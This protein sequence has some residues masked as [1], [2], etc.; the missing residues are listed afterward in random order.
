MIVRLGP[1]LV[2]ASINEAKEALRAALASGE[3]VVLDTAALTEADFAGQQLLCAVHRSA[4]RQGRSVGFAGARRGR[5]LDEVI[6][7]LGFARGAGCGSG[8]LCGEVSNG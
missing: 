8:C 6:A 3:P 7:A 4:A 5:V 1:A 2:L